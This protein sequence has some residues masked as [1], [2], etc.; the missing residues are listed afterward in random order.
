MIIKFSKN[1]KFVI[2]TSVKEVATI[3]KISSQKAREVL[4]RMETDVPEVLTSVLSDILTDV[5]EGR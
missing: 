4:K 1:G 3:F 2:E 5:E